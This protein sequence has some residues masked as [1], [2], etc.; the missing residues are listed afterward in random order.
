MA[1]SFDTSEIRRAAA[2]LAGETKKTKK[3][4]VETAARG[5]V[6]DVVAITPPGSPGNSGSG[7]KKA[8][9][10]AIASDAA[11][12]FQPMS[13]AAIRQ[14]QDFQ[15][16]ESA[17]QF[18]H[19]G[20]AALGEV[21]DVV[22]SFGQMAAFHQARRK[23]NGRV[24]GGGQGGRL[25]RERAAD[26]TTGLRRKDLRSL[27]IGIVEKSD[28]VRFITLLQK[29]VGRLAAG[30]NKAAALLG[31]R[32]PA[33]VRRHGDSAGEAGVTVTNTLFRLTV[34]NA[35]KFVGNVRAYDRR[36]QAAL[37]LQAAKM[38]RQA[39]FLMKKALKRAGW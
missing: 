24:S 21:R 18:G 36:V 31:V 34:S 1:S 20:A 4:W 5:F 17:S 39:D 22:L 23:A 11:R 2:R 33:W 27:D 28:Y 7:A 19:K 25:N 16:R 29:N 10:T 6:K 12:I 30:W 32:L 9:E 26:L 14:I 15:G 8:G 13:P 35:V 38:N 37:N 3:E